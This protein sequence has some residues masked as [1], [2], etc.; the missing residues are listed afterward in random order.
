MFA[1]PR[2]KSKQF[3]HLWVPYVYLC[4]A[5]EAEPQWSST[6]LWVAELAP[7]G[8]SLELAAANRTV[9]GAEVASLVE[10]KN[11]LR[12]VRGGKMVYLVK[13]LAVRAWQPLRG[14]STD[15]TDSS[16]CL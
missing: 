16:T 1:K 15:S 2:G 11:L 6:P 9:N 13:A 12:A 7:W 5:V 4:L 8:K 3:W 14:Q 10:R